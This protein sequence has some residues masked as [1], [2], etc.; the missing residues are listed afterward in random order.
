MFAQMLLN[1]ASNY[2]SG[3][4]RATAP[5][6]PRTQR[7]RIPVT[8]AQTPKGLPPPPRGPLAIVIPLGEGRCSAPPTPSSPAE[9]SVG[10]S[11]C[12][13]PA[14][15]IPS[16]L[17]SPLTYSPLPSPLPLPSP[18]ANPPTMFGDKPVCLD[19]LKGVCGSKR[20]NCRFAHPPREGIVNTNN[21]NVTVQPGVCETVPAAPA[22]VKR[23]CGIWMATGFCKFGTRCFF[24][25]PPRDA[26]AVNHHGLVAPLRCQ[27]PPTAE[28][29]L[30]DVKRIITVLCA[31]NVDILSEQ[32]LEKL[33]SN[34]EPMQHVLSLL[35]NKGCESQE[36]GQLCAEICSK[37]MQRSNMGTLQSTQKEIMEALTAHTHVHIAGLSE[38]LKAASLVPSERA[39]H[40]LA[41]VRFFGQLFNV[42]LIPMQ[43]L[44]D[45]IEEIFAISLG[46][47]PGTCSFAIQLLC[48]L[49][50]TA[51][52][53]LSEHGQM[54][55][56]YLHT[57][58]IAAIGHLPATIAIVDALCELWL[59]AETQNKPPPSPL[60]IAGPPFAFWPSV[61]QE[62]SLGC[63]SQL[64]AFPVNLE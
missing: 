6:A 15:T 19:Y 53:T 11:V 2:T 47:R 46:D 45:T 16:A 28:A 42:G 13:S 31:D 10:L 7:N 27:A 38:D 52:Q 61:Q 29:V 57:L 8:V 41:S 12:P 59:P 64:P 55:T 51:G 5:Q 14:S 40:L 60:S 17:S 22:S 26:T 36:L 9:S 30:T 1:G 3:F 18:V 39:T 63:F 23:N 58:R 33:A 54:L 20:P 56:Q 24:A 44:S 43:M 48:Q 49:L 25:H 35:Y 34:E 32:L 37:V 62:E 50:L 4:N 21:G